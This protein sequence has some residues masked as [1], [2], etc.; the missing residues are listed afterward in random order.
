MFSINYRF[1]ALLKTTDETLLKS[2]ETIVEWH[3]LLI[4]PQSYRRSKRGRR[5]LPILEK[6]TTVAN[7]VVIQWIPSPCGIP[8]KERIDSLA[9]QGA[10]QQQ[11]Q[12]HGQMITYFAK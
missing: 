1:L 3:S 6:A 11:R 12:E 7:T 9:K 10:Q 2:P 4:L 8:G 5:E